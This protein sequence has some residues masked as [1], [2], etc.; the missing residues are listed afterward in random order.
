MKRYFKHGPM[1]WRFSEDSPIGEVRLKD[2]ADHAWVESV[3]MIEDMKE[4]SEITEEEGEA[5]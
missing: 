4:G 2:S 1:I 5:R 3:S